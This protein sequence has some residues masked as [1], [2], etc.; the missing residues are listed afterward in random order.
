[1][2]D[3]ASYSE[4]RRYARHPGPFSGWSIGRERKEL[5]LID[6]SMGGCF[7]LEG[8]GR[9]VGEPFELRI[10]LGKD[11]LLNVSATTLYHAVNGSGVTFLDLSPSAFDQIRRTV[12]ASSAP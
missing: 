7:V 2:A 6:L 8:S 11:G 4:K 3:D 5:R 10:D 12:E 9:P 1:M